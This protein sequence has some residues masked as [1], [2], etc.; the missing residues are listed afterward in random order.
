MKQDANAIPR[1]IALDT[2]PDSFTA[3]VLRRGRLRRV[4][5]IA[6]LDFRCSA[7][8]LRQFRLYPITG[9]KARILARSRS[10]VGGVKNGARTFQSAAACKN[11]ALQNFAE[12]LNIP[13]LLRTE[14]PRSV[15]FA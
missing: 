12:P 7:S 9:L 8:R 3:A 6:R 1:V 10:A 14:S 5:A 13:K 4:R 15:R 2:H 11:R